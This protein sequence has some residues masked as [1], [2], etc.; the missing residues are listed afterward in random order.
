MVLQEPFL[1]EDITPLPGGLSIIKRTIIPAC[2]G[3]EILERSRKENER[4]RN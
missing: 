4:F 2:E 1:P 3:S